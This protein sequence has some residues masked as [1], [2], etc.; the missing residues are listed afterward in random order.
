[1]DNLSVA[2][3]LVK[4][5]FGSLLGFLRKYSAFQNYLF[6]YH[7]IYIRYGGHPIQ[8]SK[9]KMMPVITRKYTLYYS[10]G[11]QNLL[12]R[13]LFLEIAVFIWFAKYY[14]FQQNRNY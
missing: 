14:Y 8:F 11:E 6:D 5:K 10:F 3:K 13:L 12:F 1:M 2:Y 4:S 9:L 7:M